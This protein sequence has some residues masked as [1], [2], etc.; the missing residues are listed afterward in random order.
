MSESDDLDAIRARKREALR[1]RATGRHA[2]PAER[3]GPDAAPTEPVHVESRAELD[4]LV[5]DHR[6]VLAD[7]YADW[8]GPCQLLEPTVRELAEATEA[9]VAKVDIDALPALARELRVQ[10]VPTLFLYVDGEPAERLVGVQ[11]YGTL[12]ALVERHA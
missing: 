9:A 7:F 10:G 8:C 2:G 11:D 6:L 12:E 1:E 5:A 3:A 4:R